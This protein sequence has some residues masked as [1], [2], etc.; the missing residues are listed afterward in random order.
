MIPATAQ[1]R[2]PSV[3]IPTMTKEMGKTGPFIAFEELMRVTLQRP[4]V[5]IPTTAKMM[6]SLASVLRWRGGGGGT[7]G[8]VDCGSLID[9]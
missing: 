8:I 4:K 9:V 1:T 7:D 5:M 3:Q 2:R 6:A